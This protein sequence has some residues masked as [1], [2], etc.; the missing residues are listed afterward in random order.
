MNK[1]AYELIKK[2]YKEIEEY[3]SNPKFPNGNHPTLAYQKYNIDGYFVG[4]INSLMLIR[5]ELRLELL[6]TQIMI[7]NIG[8]YCLLEDYEIFEQVC[9]IFDFDIDKFYE[10]V[11]KE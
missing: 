4:M 5:N 7:R 10:D 1:K 6:K 9:R 8:E 2:C 11:D 3:E